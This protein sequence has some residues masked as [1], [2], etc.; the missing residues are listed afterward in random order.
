M[1]K[2]RSDPYLISWKV[3][4]TFS[5]SCETFSRDPVNSTLT[6][7]IYD[8]S[9]DLLD[10]MTSNLLAEFVSE[11]TLQKISAVIVAFSVSRSRLVRVFRTQT[12]TFSE[13]RRIM[14]C[15]FLHASFFKP[16]TY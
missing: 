9:F 16:N 14:D 13:Y 6:E 15:I 10:I 12:F 7:C 1:L 8:V 2:T 4:F 5:H 11:K 3:F